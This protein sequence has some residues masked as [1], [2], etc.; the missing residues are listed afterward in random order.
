LLGLYGD[1]PGIGGRV[2]LEREVVALVRAFPEN[3]I[4]FGLRLLEDEVSRR[5]E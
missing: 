2:D 5:A 1:A 3:Q 4:A